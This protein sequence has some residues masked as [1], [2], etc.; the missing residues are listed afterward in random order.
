VQG[1]DIGRIIGI[2]LLAGHENKLKFF[3]EA[4][5]EIFSGHL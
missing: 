3:I 1:G 2:R 4:G 5:Y